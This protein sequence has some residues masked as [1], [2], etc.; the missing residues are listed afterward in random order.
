MAIEPITDDAAPDAWSLLALIATPG[1]RTL[2]IRS[3]DA[4]EVDA[5]VS[6]RGCVNSHA[7]TVD[8]AV[9]A[10]GSSHPFDLVGIADGFEQLADPIATLKEAARLL[11]AS[12]RIV[13]VA[14]NAASVRARLRAL[15]GEPTTDPAALPPRQYD[16]AALERVVASAGLVVHERL[17]VF[18]ED[19]PVPA[20]LAE[21]VDGPDVHT[22]AFVLVVAPPV[23]DNAPG[24]ESLAEVLQQQIES[25]SRRIARAAADHA[26]VEAA[27]R[28]L[29]DQLDAA[30]AKLADATQQLDDQNVELASRADALAERVELVERLHTE[31]RHLELDLAVKDDYIAD[32]RSEFTELLNRFNALLYKHEVILRSR[33]YKLTKLVRR[34]LGRSGEESED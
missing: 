32:L 31:R 1:S 19:V 34:L 9:D 4:A 5:K 11:A 29:A 13:V 27:R 30:E 16:L 17:R 14:Q 8:A 12:G 25:A 20:E 28:D 33:P 24:G 6:G 10:F 3:A 15:L 7:V 26:A 2:V 18:D 21:L 22:G 23:S